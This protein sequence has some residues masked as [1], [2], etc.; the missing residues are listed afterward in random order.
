M[1]VFIIEE[2][3]SNAQYKLCHCYQLGIG[4]N[5]VENKAFEYYAKSRKP[6]EQQYYRISFL[7]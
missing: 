4:T 2:G 5:R 1:I 7:F 3:N 6:W